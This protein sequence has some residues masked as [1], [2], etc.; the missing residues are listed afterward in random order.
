MPPFF[1]KRKKIANLKIFLL[2]RFSK[3]KRKK[4]KLMKCNIFAKTKV[5]PLNKK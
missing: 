1:K 3:K 2:G 4:K 5:N